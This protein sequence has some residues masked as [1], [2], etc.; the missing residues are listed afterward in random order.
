MHRLKS[1][2]GLARSG[3]AGQQDQVPR[4][5]RSGLMNDLDQSFK[6]RLGG[7]C[8]PSY[9]PQIPML[10][11]LAGCLH[12]CGQRPIGIFREEPLDG[13][14]VVGGN[15]RELLS[16]YVQDV[17]TDDAHARDRREF[18]NRLGEDEKWMHRPCLALPVVPAQVSCIAGRLVDIGERGRFLTLQFE[19]E[20]GSVEQQHDV[21]PPVLRGS[22]YSRIAE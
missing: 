13:D 19:H 15:V 12:E 16:R 14:R 8:S 9:P 7:G 18:S 6:S 2:E 11:Q 17:G 20:D 3:H 10:E 5:R 21:R 1:D 4:S 22:S